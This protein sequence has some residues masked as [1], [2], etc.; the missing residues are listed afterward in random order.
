MRGAV[1]VLV[2]LVAL[3]GCCCEEKEEVVEVV[4]APTG[5]HLGQEPPGTTPELFLATG[6]GERDTAI[7]PDGEQLFYSMWER[8]HGYLVTR[9]EGPEGWSEPGFAPFSSPEHSELEP[10]VT[11][12]GEWLYFISKRPL[13]DGTEPEKYDL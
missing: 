3:T 4:P 9:T 12:D 8:N 13:P 10:F 2:G 6:M 7:T 1:L 5:P 11:A